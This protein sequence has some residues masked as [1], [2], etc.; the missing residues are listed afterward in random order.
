M[1]GSNWGEL[2]NLSPVIKRE[3]QAIKDN[4]L[5]TLKNDTKN[6]VSIISF[7]ARFYSQIRTKRKTEKLIK[8]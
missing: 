6:C 8:E 5:E 2:D 4:E 1:F 7:T 3:I